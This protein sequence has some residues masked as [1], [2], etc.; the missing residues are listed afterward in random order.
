MD[1]RSPAYRSVGSIT[2]WYLCTSGLLVVFVLTAW[3]ST[4]T[5]ASELVEAVQ[6]IQ[7]Y[8]VLREF[9]REVEL[10]LGQQYMTGSWGGLR[11]RLSNA[12]LTATM[13]Y[14][15]DLLGNPIGG[16]QHGFRYTG[17]FGIDPAFD[18]E[19]GLG[20]KGLLLDVSGV[21]RA[22]SNLSAT[23]IGNT[24]NASN[25]FSGR[26]AATLRHCPGTI[27]PRRS[28]GHPRGALWDRGRF[29]SLAAL[30]SLRERRL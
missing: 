30:Y 7:R 19:K 22:G 4:S 27:P 26:Y 15:T 9:W 1:A 5:Q 17:D 8:P 23:D 14:T 18:L 11:N 28:S 6:P 10:E 21:W 12:G 3:S 25:I 16:R 24:F 29:S 2:D 13:T 20:V